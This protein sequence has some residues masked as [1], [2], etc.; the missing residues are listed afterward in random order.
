MRTTIFLRH[1]LYCYFQNIHHTEHMFALTNWKLV[2]TPVHCVQQVS[3]MVVVDLGLGQ[4]VVVTLYSE[5]HDIKCGALCDFT[6]ED[7]DVLS[8]QRKDKHNIPLL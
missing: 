6:C 4:S 5:E 7:N 3:G 8:L 1:I 2:I